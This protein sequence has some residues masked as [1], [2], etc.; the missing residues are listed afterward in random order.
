MKAIV[1]AQPGGIEELKTVDIEKPVIAAGEVLVQVKAISINPVDVKSRA[2]K[3]FYG[4]ISSAN[5]VILGW[6]IAGV[7][8]E[9]NNAA[10]K[11]G[12]EVFGMVNFPGH[13]KA[14]AEYVAVPASQLAIKPANIS[15]E[16]AAAATLAALT[17]Y[18]ALVTNANITPG[19]RVLVHA[20][21]G[22]VG[23][24]AVQIAK[25]QGAHVTG[26]S[27]AANRDF[28][29]G[30]GADGHIDYKN[31][32]WQQNADSFDLILDGLGA[33]SFALS[34]NVAKP[35]GTII[36][37]LGLNDANK[38]KAVAKGINA[39]AILVQSSGVDMKVLAGWLE[40]GMVKAQ[41][42]ATFPFEKM[43]EAHLHVETGRTVGKVVVTV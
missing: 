33:D 11:P 41:I 1:L 20:A 28:V 31:H 21:A 19:Q 4:S 40:K 34:I 9:A 30:L 25:Q 27:S 24:F 5:P 18:Q 39:K 23:H 3:G 38:E 13:G 6:D 2:G 8:V 42:A 17:A 26:T 10:F 32:N 14:Y 36:S 37:I 12:D 22:G 43:G 29:L 35:G 16:E 7:V 15:F